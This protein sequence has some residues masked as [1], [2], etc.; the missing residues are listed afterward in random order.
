MNMRTAS[1]RIDVM[2]SQFMKLL[3]RVDNDLRLDTN[4]NSTARINEFIRPIDFVIYLWPAGWLLLWIGT[5]VR[6]KWRQQ[7]CAYKKRIDSDFIQVTDY[8]EE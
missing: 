6:P 2:S 3:S 4:P 8:G 1:I 5:R 7:F